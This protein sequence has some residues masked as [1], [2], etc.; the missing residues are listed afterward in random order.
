MAKTNNGEKTTR[1]RKKTGAL[2]SI[3]GRSNYDAQGRENLD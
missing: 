1:R 3:T 2:G